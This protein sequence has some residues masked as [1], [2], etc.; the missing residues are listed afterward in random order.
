MRQGFQTLPPCELAT[1]LLPIVK[2]SLPREHVAQKYANKLGSN[3]EARGFAKT[4][5]DKLEVTIVP[6]HFHTRDEGVAVWP[7]GVTSF[8]CDFRSEPKSRGR[9]LP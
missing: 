8:A 1:E 7:F 5:A 2:L 4:A 3:N 9:E 6:L